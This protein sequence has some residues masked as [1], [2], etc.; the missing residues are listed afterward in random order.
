VRQNDHTDLQSECSY[1]LGIA[2]KREIYL[3]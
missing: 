2:S 1:T 3:F